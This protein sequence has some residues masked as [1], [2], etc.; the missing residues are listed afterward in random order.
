MTVWIKEACPVCLRRIAVSP[1]GGTI[2]AHTDKAGN[3]CPMSGNP[4]G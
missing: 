3:P 1:F 4:V 2:V